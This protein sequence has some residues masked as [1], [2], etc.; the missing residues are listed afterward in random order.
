MKHLKTFENIYR[1]Y[2]EG[3]YVIINSNR[4]EHLR[5]EVG[6]IIQIANHKIM[7]EY[8]N[9]TKL[10]LVVYDSEIMYWSENKEELEILLA[11]KKYNL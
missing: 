3:D 8:P 11:S 1:P 6:Q 7:I 4:S 10:P 2:Q 9:S 5:S